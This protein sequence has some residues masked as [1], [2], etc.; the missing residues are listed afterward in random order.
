MIK[1]WLGFVAGVTE[2]IYVLEGKDHTAKFQSPF[3][4]DAGMDRGFWMGIHF[5]RARFRWEI[6]PNP[7]LTL[8]GYYLGVPRIR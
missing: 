7:T 2:W 5:A 4:D 6:K 8:L 1:N 3:R